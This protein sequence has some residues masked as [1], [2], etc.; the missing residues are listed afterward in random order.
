MSKISPTPRSFWLTL[1]TFTTIVNLTMMRATY[2]HLIEIKANLLRSTWSGMLVLC[3]AIAALC[4]WLI[5]RNSKSKSS[6]FESLDRIHFANNIW[7]VGGALVFPAILILIPYIK[8][9]FGIGQEVKNPVYDPILLLLLYYWMCWW[10]V[11]LA[12]TALKATLRTSWVGG[13]ATALV[14]LG[15]AYEIM[16]RFNSVT[17]YP[18]SLGWSEGSRYYYSSLFLSKQIYGEVFPLSTLHPTRYLLQSFPFLIPSLGLFAHRIWQYLLWIGLTAGASIAI[19]KRTFSENENALQWLTAGWLF[20]FLLR[21]GVYYHLE[22]MVILPV[23]FVS[24]KKPWRSLVILIV[25]SLWAGVSR[26]NWFPMPAMIIIALY[27]LETPLTSNQSEKISFKKVTQY[28]KMPAIWTFIGLASALFA[29][30]MYV[31]ISGNAQNADA[32][33]SSFTSD[34]LWYR[35]WPNENFTMGVIPAILFISGPLIFIIAVA[36]R[37]R[38][39]LHSIRWLGLI[40]M[41][42]ALFAGSAVVSTKIGG[43]GDL[44]NMDTYAVL[45]GIVGLHLFG[46][47]VYVEPGTPKLEVRPSPAFAVALVTP[48]LFL[49]PMLSPYPRYNESRNQQAYHQLIDVVHEVGQAGPVLFI[50]DRQL[51]ALGDVD[52]PL[53]YDYEVVTLMEMAM[54]G[55]QAYLNR[56]YDDL[57]NHRFAAII[58]GR[59][60]LIIK[61]EGSFAEENN[62][63]NTY[64]SPYI[65]CYYE[66]SATIEADGTR[67]E[68]YVPRTQSAICPSGNSIE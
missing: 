17:D 60:F 13:F 34:L 47:R 9:K 6:I 56:F 59:Q 53:V 16:V 29:Q 61:E 12:A 24:W 40:T 41:L 51:I 36:V 10:M 37:R 32:F 65:L 54:S 39:S 25:A 35:L 44:H 67:I 3:F 1:L 19:T 58:S 57:E 28:L 63:W 21:V 30:W 14:L 38:T 5:I 64:V 4:I 8:F 52:V 23:L 66:S 27:L 26:V 50:N 48:L 31:Y 15:V 33:T 22:V 42:V 55:N 62:V 7:R 45:I 20:L 11:L 2:L 46:G 18:L 68:I 49:I 43:G